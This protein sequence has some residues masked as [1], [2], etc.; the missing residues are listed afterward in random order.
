MA[1]GW[2]GLEIGD[3]VI[4]QGHKGKIIELFVRDKNGGVIETDDGKQYLVVC[5]LCKKVEKEPTPLCPKCLLEG[6][7]AELIENS[8]LKRC[9]RCTYDYKFDLRT[10]GRGKITK[11]LKG[12]KAILG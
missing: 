11:P 8:L 4:Y 3:E 10:D 2:Y 5:E 9:V 6:H 1:K 12:L 7:K